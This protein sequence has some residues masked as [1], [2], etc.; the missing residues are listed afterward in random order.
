MKGSVYKRCYCRDPETKRELGQK[1]PQLRAKGHGGWWYRYEA[2]AAP[3]EKRRQPKVGPFPTRKA[4]QEELTATLARIGGGAAVTDRGLLVRDYLANWLKGKRLEL[5]PDS[6]SSYEEAVRLYFAPGV[7]HL[8]LVDLRDH[9]LQDLVSAMLLI[10][11]PAGDDLKPAEAELLRR[12]A[13]VRADDARRVVPEGEKRHKKSTKPLSPARIERLFAVI[14][15]ALNDAVP[16]KIGVSPYDGVVLPRVARRKPLPWTPQREARF[17]DELGKRTRNAEAAAEAERRVLTTVERQAL[18]TSPELLPAPSMVWMPDHAG[19]FLDYLDE[20]GER[21]AVLFIVTMF[22][23]LRRDEVLGLTWAEV[24]L[25]EGVLYVRE[26]ASGDG[27]KSEAGVRPVPIP[28]PALEALKAWR[29]VQDRDRL[30]WGPDWPDARGLVFTR[31][32]GSAV[33]AQWTSIRF[34]ILAYRALLP[35]VRFHDLRHGTAS[36]MKAAKADTKFISAV[37]G[38][39][40]TSF[41]D[42]QYVSLFPE[43]QKA[44]AEA[45]A[46]IV[47]RKPRKAVAEGGGS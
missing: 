34:E 10:N 13:A 28:A 9:H 18:W 21:L 15:A 8:R 31:E 41:T 16:S 27:P 19:A 36:L 29:K 25:D 6:Y 17:R 44:V 5:K 38:H 32:D 3:G 40:R 20:T 35:P 45:A 2:P 1:C 14:R 43:V 7:G 37:L 26:T 30:A 23:G 46:A 4:A 47:P 42:S 24:D 11:Q 12:L 33:P 39:S 22:C